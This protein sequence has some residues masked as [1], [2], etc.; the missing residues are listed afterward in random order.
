MH[1]HFPAH[2]KRNTDA[3]ATQTTRHTTAG[4][5][6]CVHVCNHAYM[7]ARIHAFMSVTNT[8]CTH[9]RSEARETARSLPQTCVWRNLCSPSARV[10]LSFPVRLPFT[11]ACTSQCT[12]SSQG[13]VLYRKALEGLPTTLLATIRFCC[14]LF[15]VWGF[16]REDDAPMLWGRHLVLVMQP[17]TPLNPTM[18]LVHLW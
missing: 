8:Q 3:D 6:A 5:Q 14:D 13:D 1:T 17:A 12:M 4:T 15:R 10:V 2:E 18:L 16:T 11:Y 7:H 9:K